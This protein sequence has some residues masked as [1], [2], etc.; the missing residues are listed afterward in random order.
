ME[1]EDDNEGDEGN[2]GLPGDCGYYLHSWKLVFPHP[3]ELN[4]TIKVISP[5]PPQLQSA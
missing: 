3:T 4:R 1:K 5:P 2:S